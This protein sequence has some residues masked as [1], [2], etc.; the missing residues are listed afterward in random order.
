[1]RLYCDCVVSVC[2]SGHVCIVIVVFAWVYACF[3]MC[4]FVLCLCFVCMCIWQCLYGECE[5]LRGCMY[6]CECVRLYGDCVVC[7]C[8]SGNVY[9]VIVGVCMG[10]C[11]FVNACVLVWW[12]CCFC[13]CLWPCVYGDCG[14]LPV[15]IHVCECV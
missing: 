5:G 15:C 13:M 6:N 8:V 10:A 7:L 12:L 14:C 9:V 3:Q 4:V 2:V 11:M 1:M